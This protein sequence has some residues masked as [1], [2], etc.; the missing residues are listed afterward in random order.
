MNK[1]PEEVRA[2]ET[3]RIQREDGDPVL[4]DQAQTA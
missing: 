2:A 4:K 1:A 3:G